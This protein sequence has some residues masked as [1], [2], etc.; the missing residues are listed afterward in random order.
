MKWRSETGKTALAAL[1]LML[2]LAVS[3]YYLAAGYGAYLDADMSSEL[4]LAQHL[5]ETGRLISQD[6]LYSTEVRVLNTQLVFTPLMA[7]FGADWQLVRVLGCLILL[8][9]MAASCVFCARMLGARMSYALVFAGI[10]V[11]PVS[12]VYA[13]MIVIG[14]YYVPHAILTNLMIGL[15]AAAAG[16]KRRG[17][18]LALLAALSLVMGASSIRYLLCAAIPS[19]AAGIWMAV[20]PRREKMD[21]TE[22]RLVA[23]S[24]GSAALSAVGYVLGQKWLNAQFDFGGARYNGSRLVALTSEN[25]FELLDQAFDGLIKLMGFLEGRIM[26]SAQGLL[27]VGALGL[28]VLSALLCMRAAKEAKAEDT[29]VDGPAR[30]GLLALVFSAA[31]TLFTF[32]FVDGLYLNRYWL[33]VMTLGA[34]VMAMCLSRERRCALRVLGLAAFACVVLGLSAVQIRSSMANPE[35]GEDDWH[36]AQLVR[37]SGITLGYA[38]FWNANVLTELT[39]GEI[40][41]VGMMIVRNAQD[42]AYPE[43]SVWLE[44][45]DNVQESRP[46]EP[47]FLLLGEDEA[48]ELEGFLTACE[49][50]K[51]LLDGERLQMHVVQSQHRLFEV[52]AQFESGK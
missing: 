21:G 48:Q 23:F 51:R 2:C 18:S 13:Q 34:P 49:A 40:E 19:A 8:A 1:L 38:S 42:Q 12:V 28:L 30:Y 7:I 50:E 37:E 36:K 47:V 3:G 45:R 32:V 9:L 52:I 15:T 29:R 5:A 44:T 41:V 25:L 11:L 17:A 31:V 43:M 27:S 35:I 14:A 4:A 6:W 26:L 24:L 46:D 10:G 16:K 20:F 22:R 39:D 33:P